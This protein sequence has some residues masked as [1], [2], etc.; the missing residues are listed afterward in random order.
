MSGHLDLRVLSMLGFLCFALAT[1]RLSSFDPRM[2]WSSSWLIVLL[3]SPLF[4]V[5]PWSPRLIVL[6][7]TF[8]AP[9]AAL[10]P[11]AGS[12]VLCSVFILPV[13]SWL[14][15]PIL[16]NLSSVRPRLCL[17]GALLSLRKALFLCILQKRSPFFSIQVKGREAHEQNCWFLIFVLFTYSSFSKSIWKC[18]LWFFCGYVHYPPLTF[19]R[20]PFLPTSCP[21]YFLQ[22]FFITHW[23]S[24]ALPI[25]VY[26]DRTI[27]WSMVDLPRATPQQKVHSPPQQP[28]TVACFSAR[29]GAYESFPFPFRPFHARVLTGFILTRI[30]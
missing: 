2:V 25:Y 6:P 10:S 15:W 7:C 12:N 13:R 24:L 26:D 16:Q 29:G 22:F 9:C 4:A 14:N 20:S 3:D 17:A 5:H 30:Q 8:A 19:P 21:P 11:P 27:H 28:P 23:I 18:I 1:V